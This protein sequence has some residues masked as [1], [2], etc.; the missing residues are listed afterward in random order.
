MGQVLTHPDIGMC[1]PFVAVEGS[2]C[3]GD[4]WQ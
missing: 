2:S 1:L 4:L 3:S